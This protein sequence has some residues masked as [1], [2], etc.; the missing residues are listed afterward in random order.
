MTRVP[1]I[2]LLS[3]WLMAGGFAATAEDEA[4]PPWLEG[5]AAVP[6]HGVGMT[7][8]EGWA[9]FDPSGDIGAQWQ[10]V[11]DAW[12]GRGYRD[13]DNTSVFG[14]LF[15]LSGPD[16]K[17]GFQ[18]CSIRPVPPGRLEE[19]VDALE[20]EVSDFG[21]EILERRVIDLPAG[22]TVVIDSGIGDVLQFAQY[23]VDGPERDVL[24]TCMVLRERPAD[25]WLSIAQTLEFVPTTTQVEGDGFAF[26]V[27]FDWTVH[28]VDRA[29]HS[30]LFR[31]AADEAPGWEGL[32]YA[33][34]AEF[35]CAVI[36]ATDYA[37]A[38]GFMD[39]EDAV[40]WELAAFD[41]PGSSPRTRI[42]HTLSD[43]PEDVSGDTLV[44]PAGSTG[45][46]DVDDED[47]WHTRTYVLTDGARWFYF[48][49]DDT[50]EPPADRWLAYA[51]T[52]EFTGDD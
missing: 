52:F 24:L 7:V 29:S 39:V 4:G 9:A 22:P 15:L 6:T 19:A 34:D 18:E 5:L 2:L 50:F 8:P 44:L 45:I 21:G 13:A 37:E 42:V 10:V 51:V 43:D 25:D 26:R 20:Q 30:W 1:M 28:A 49:C 38:N 36:D 17:P 35:S 14:S 32:A 48:H 40:A 12:G 33:T 16:V 11:E 23:V 3:G 41:D 31:D 47:W 46:I 27:P